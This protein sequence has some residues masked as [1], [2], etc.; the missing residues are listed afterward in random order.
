MYRKEGDGKSVGKGEKDFRS[1]VEKAEKVESVVTAFLVEN[2]YL[3]A[4]Q[5]FPCRESIF[6]CIIVLTLI[7][8]Y[9]RCFGVDVGALGSNA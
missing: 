2:I 3:L 7:H 6:F 5:A 8:A 9:C 1:L 4:Y